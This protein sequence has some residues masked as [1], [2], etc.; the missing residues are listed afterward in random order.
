LCLLHDTLTSASPR[1]IRYTT[2]EQVDGKAHN[3]FGDGFAVW[4]SKDR[5][6]SGPVFG[7]V[8]KSFCSPIMPEW[9]ADF[10]DYFTGLGLFFDT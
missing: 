10:P 4:L 6:K 2:D 8:G 5:A 3:I 1:Q 9:P 7:S